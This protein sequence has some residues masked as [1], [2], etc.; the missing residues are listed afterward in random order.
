MTGI[1]TG[2]PGDTWILNITE[3][4]YALTRGAALSKIPHKA[5]PEITLLHGWMG[6]VCY[7]LLR[8]T[9]KASFWL[10]LVDNALQ[11]YSNGFLL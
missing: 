11:R 1:G 8:D 10:Y 3:G 6:A 7:E 9:L 5:N 4:S 2:F